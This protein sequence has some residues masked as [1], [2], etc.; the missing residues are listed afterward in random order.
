MNIGTSSEKLAWKSYEHGNPSDALA[1]FTALA[2]D[3]KPYYL[4]V[5]ARMHMDGVGTEVDRE[6]ARDLLDQAISVGVTEAFLQ[7]ALLARL[8]GDDAA[9]FRL[10]NE[11]VNRGCGPSRYYLGVC[12]LEGL[13]TNRDVAKAMS[14]IQQASSGGNL[15]AQILLAR[16]FL[17]YPGSLLQFFRGLRLLL[18]ASARHV[19]LAFANP[20]D[21]RLR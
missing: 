13:G 2:H 19:Y 6:R 14:L 20:H 10:L 4:V 12:Y 18:S 16:R 7:R 5:A 17:R 1:L 11:A 3:G 21:E 15:G 9:Y 8:E